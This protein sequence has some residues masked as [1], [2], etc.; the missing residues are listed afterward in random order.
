MPITEMGVF[1]GKQEKTS[2]RITGVFID[3]GEGDRE[4][5]R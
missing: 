5:D 1:F 3:E 4:W 2:L